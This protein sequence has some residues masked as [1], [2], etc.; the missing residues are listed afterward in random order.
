[1]VV[2]HCIRRFGRHGSRL[3]GRTRLEG[4]RIVA[5]TNRL[6]MKLD[7]VQNGGSQLGGWKLGLGAPAARNK[8]QITAPVVGYLLQENFV[9][10][11]HP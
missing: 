2:P 8:F 5:G 1:M 7:E 9:R 11:I 6:L 4:S 10:R 3:H